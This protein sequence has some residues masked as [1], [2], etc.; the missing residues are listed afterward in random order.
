MPLSNVSTYYRFSLVFCPLSEFGQVKSAMMTTTKVSTTKGK[1]ISREGM[2][3]P[4]TPWSYG[5]GEVDGTKLLDPGLTFDITYND[6]VNFLAGRNEKRARALFGN[7]DPMLS[8]QLNLPTIV[9]SNLKGAV[10][11][12]RVVKNVAKAASLYQATVLAPAGAKVTIAPKSMTI[13]PQADAYFNV[14]FTAVS[15]STSFSF[16]TLTWTDYKGHYV[17]CILGVQGAPA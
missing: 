10:V 4:T 12:T 9:V 17:R 16:G 7:V 5:A 14:T 15:L 1:P 13:Q 2:A 3:G 11:I 8:F 6:Y